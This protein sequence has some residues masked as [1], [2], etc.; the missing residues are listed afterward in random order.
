[1]E[2]ALEM[3]LRGYHFNNI[4]LTKSQA[5]NFIIDPD[6]EFGII[7]SFSSIDGLGAAVADSIVEQREIQ[8]FISKEDLMKR[9]SVNNTQLA[10]LERMGVLDHLAEENQLSLF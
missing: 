6:D 7:P 8:S 4:C 3:Y 1:M 9:T 10:F 5:T 2:I